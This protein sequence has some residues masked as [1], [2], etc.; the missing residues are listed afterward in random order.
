[1]DLIEQIGPILGIV[2][3][4]GL[5]VLVFLLFQQS[6]DVRRLREWAGRA[7]ERAQDA[8]E[9]RA[10]AAEAR[11]EAAAS[12]PTPPGRIRRALDAARARIAG[13]FHAVDS[14][15]PIDSRIVVAVLVVVVVAV[16]VLTSGFGL[17]GE[18]EGKGSESPLPPPSKTQVAVLNGTQSESGSA[19]P[20]LAALV[21]DEVLKP[22]KYKVVVESDAPAGRENTTVMFA[23]GQRRA[24]QRLAGGIQR[25]LGRAPVVAM[26]DPVRAAAQ[27]ADLALLIG[28]D[29]ATF[30]Q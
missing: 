3:F 5:C 18:D 21:S 13:A 7:P 8:A 25:Q 26:S 28:L 9:A 20:G 10:A 19:V 23:H 30:G 11:G 12:E 16:G 6:R 29:N 15:L 22:L 4:A 27:K 2:A 17:V 24:A 14:R 1:L